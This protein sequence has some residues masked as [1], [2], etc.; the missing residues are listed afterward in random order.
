M[1]L[2]KLQYLGML[3]AIQPIKNL[4][5]DTGKHDIVNEQQETKLQMH[6]NF[7]QDVYSD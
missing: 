2:I 1:N 3:K 4:F 7:L 5:N 6:V